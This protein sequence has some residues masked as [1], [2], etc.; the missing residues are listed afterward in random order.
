MEPEQ[1]SRFVIIPKVDH[2]W[3]AEVLRGSLMQA[4]F[5]QEKLHVSISV[6]YSPPATATVEAQDS[7]LA[8]VMATRPS[9]IAIDPVGDPSEMPAMVA[10][11]G[12]GIP[13]IVFDSPL[14]DPSF[15]SVGNDFIQQ[16]TIAARRLVALIGGSG[17]VAIMQG[18][19][20]APNHLQRYRAQLEVLRE[21]PAV[22]VVDGGVDHDDIATAELQATGVLGSHPDLVGYLCCDA[23]GPIGIAAAIRAAGKIGKV[24][25]VG[26]DGIEPILEGIKEGVLDSSVATIPVMQGSM[27]LLMLWE[28]SQGMPIPQKVD[29]GIDVITPDNVDEFLARVGV[30]SPTPRTREPATN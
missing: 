1:I 14:S 10:V 25:V 13:L 20:A 18:V 2:P 19:P 5:L 12:H 23:S 28:A 27:A 17:E 21:H 16:G 15:P 4:R 24:N 8:R 30:S 9:G 7:V 22:T 6:D 26:M 29:T 11:R 3:F